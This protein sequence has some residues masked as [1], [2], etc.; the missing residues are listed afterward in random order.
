MRVLSTL[1]L[2]LL[3][4]L[5][6]AAAPHPTLQLDIA[7][8]R[9]EDVGIRGNVVEV[10]A[11]VSGKWLRYMRRAPKMYQAAAVL[12]LEIVRPDG[13]AAYQETVT[14]K[15]PV[16]SDTTAAIK[17]P[18]SFQKRIILPDGEYS[19]R[20]LVR[21]QYHKGQ[22]SLVEMP[23]VLKSTDTKPVLSDIVLL[24]KPAARGAEAS[25]FS[26]SGFSLTRAPGGLYARGQEKLFLYT[27]LYNAAVGQPLQVTFRLRATNLPAG[28][29]AKTIA[30]GQTT[31][32]G[33]QGRPT[34][35]V[36][37]LSLGKVPSG[38]YLLTV[39]VRNAKNQLL[40]SQTALVQRETEEYAPAGAG[41]A[42]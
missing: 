33:A 4:R 42:R 31:A 18:L 10:Y 26:R 1:F 41:P 37:E 5:T 29:A 22:Q 36:G 3:L 21:D 34:T 2:L 19:L 14:L 39:E 40:A 30:T 23:L 15:P 25:T 7:R 6:A 28:M 13:Q 35:L 8:F 12:T 9:N 38:E 17:N 20:A 16:L 32:T 27:E 24:A 11:T